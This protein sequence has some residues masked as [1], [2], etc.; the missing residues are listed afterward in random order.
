MVIQKT[1]N[2]LKD[3]PKDERQAVAIG[4]AGAV[5]IILIIGWAFIFLKSLRQEQTTSGQAYEIP[6]QDVSAAPAMQTY[7][8]YNATQQPDQFGLP[9]QQ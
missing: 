5:V 6:P 3:R 7:Q 1:V 9:G 8:S 4:T 2:N